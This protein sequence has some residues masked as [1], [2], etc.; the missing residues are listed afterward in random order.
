MKLFVQNYNWANSIRSIGVRC[1][2]LIPE[3]GPLQL[4]LLVDEAGRRKLQILDRTMDGLRK[5]FGHFCIQRASVV[6]D[7]ALGAINPK[8]DHIIHPV[9]FFKDRMVE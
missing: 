2:D 5:R 3:S 6:A 7:R 4:S 8:D 1:T 9:G